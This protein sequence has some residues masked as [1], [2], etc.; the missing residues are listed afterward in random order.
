[1]G[2]IE[3]PLLTRRTRRITS[4]NN[5][6]TPKP[7]V[8]VVAD[9]ESNAQPIILDDL[10]RRFIWL[11]MKLLLAALLGEFFLWSNENRVCWGPGGTEP[12][13]RRW[14]GHLGP[15]RHRRAGGY[16]RNR[17]EA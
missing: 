3:E 12:R 1:M 9:I 11:D 14:R 13:A 17:H 16:S 8:V 4:E 2:E 7:E 15:T 5:L 10:Q 6:E